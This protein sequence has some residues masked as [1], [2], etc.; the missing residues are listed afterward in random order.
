MSDNVEFIEWTKQQ[1]ELRENDRLESRI[2]ELEEGM[3]IIL[4]IAKDDGGCLAD[5]ENVAKRLMRGE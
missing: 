4:D 1:N 5:A 2:R 3:N